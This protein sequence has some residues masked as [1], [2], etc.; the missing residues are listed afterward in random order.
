LQVQSLHIYPV[1]GARAVDLTTCDLE[2]MGLAE[3]RRWM[4][5]NADGMFLSQ[6]D[7]PA[8]AKLA[9]KPARNGGL[10]ISVPGALTQ[11]V[12][13]PDPSQPTISVTV[14]KYTGPALAAGKDV[15]DLLSRWLGQPVR[16]VRVAPTTA[17]LANPDWAGPHTPVGFADAYPVLVALTASL[18]ALNAAMADAI[19]MNRFRP[20][21][22]ISGAGAWA[23]DGWKRIRLGEVELDLVKPSDRCLVTTTDQ[24]SGERMGKEPLATLAKL[25]RSAVPNINGVLFGTNAAPR[26]LGTLS[27]GD[28]VEVLETREP[29]AL[30][31][32][33]P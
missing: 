33:R 19:A 13:P 17:R 11:L 12:L 21:I 23:D 15:N 18:D 32:E 29:W 1:K 4:L 14:W 30:H 31:T 6:R 25:R 26:V 28:I 3:D 20:N 10:M 24:S 8:L 22:V 2:P 27:V 9:V 16:L 7:T 5:V